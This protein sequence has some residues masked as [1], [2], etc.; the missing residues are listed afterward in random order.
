MEKRFCREP[1]TVWGQKLVL[2]LQ[3]RRG[4]HMSR[5]SKVLLQEKSWR[6][7]IC[8]ERGGLVVGVVVGLPVLSLSLFSVLRVPQILKTC[9]VYVSEILDHASMRARI[10]IEKAL[11]CRR[12]SLPVTGLD[13]IYR[14]LCWPFP[15]FWDDA[16]CISWF[17]AGSLFWSLSCVWSRKTLETRMWQVFRVVV[18]GSET[19]FR[20]QSQHLIET[21]QLQTATQA[22][23]NKAKQS[24][25]AAPIVKVMLDPYVV[26]WFAK[27]WRF[28]EPIECLWSNPRKHGYLGA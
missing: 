23:F 12:S 18:H 4:I 14:Q 20:W 21:D 5:R 9:C 15:K 16:F 22:C 2:K 7:R 8:R 6:S 25:C 17:G 28:R 1:W 19:I 27:T 3:Q 24:D 10:L 13:L 26:S 11:G